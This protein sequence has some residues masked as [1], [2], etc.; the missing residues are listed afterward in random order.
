MMLKPFAIVCMLCAS[1]AAIADDAQTEW[2][3]MPE[4]LKSGW[5]LPK[6]YLMAGTG[7]MKAELGSVSMDGYL[8][9]A[10]MG[11]KVGNYVALEARYIS[12]PALSGNSG[13]EGE[14]KGFGS[15]VTVYLPLNHRSKAF[16]RY[17]LLKLTAE[18]EKN[19]IKAEQEERVSSYSVGV[20]GRISG[21]NYMRGSYQL[22]KGDLI[23][24]EVI[25]LAYLRR[26]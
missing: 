1:C 18:V 24:G 4:E 11:V 22:L 21:K 3:P 16:V 12:A 26:I 25:E 8:A 17:D 20:E 10:G 7:F 19:S 13:M 9:Q 5:K 2:K 14:I 23:E 6:A 15:G